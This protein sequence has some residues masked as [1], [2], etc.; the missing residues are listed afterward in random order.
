MIPACCQWMSFILA[1]NPAA[2]FKIGVQ[3]KLLTLKGHVTRVGLPATACYWW[4][5]KWNTAWHVYICIYI[6]Q[7]HLLFINTFHALPIFDVKDNGVC[8]THCFADIITTHIVC[9]IHSMIFVVFFFKVIDKRN[10]AALTDRHEL[11]LWHG[12]VISCRF[13]IY[14]I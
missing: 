11:R 1:W 12:E 8:I 14:Y 5:P 3:R 13:F 7:S 2:S 6:M 4:A 10:G 9:K